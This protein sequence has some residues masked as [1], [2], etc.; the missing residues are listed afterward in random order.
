MSRACYRSIAP[1]AHGS[2]LAA[3]LVQQLEKLAERNGHRIERLAPLGEK[4]HLNH[5]IAALAL[6]ATQDLPVEADFRSHVIEIDGTDE[7][8]TEPGHPEASVRIKSQC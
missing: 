4:R 6:D 5:P 1:G 8:D 2:D 7:V 3:Y